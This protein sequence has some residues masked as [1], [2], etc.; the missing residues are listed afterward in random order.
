MPQAPAPHHQAATG[1]DRKKSIEARRCLHRGVPAAAATV[2]PARAP[3]LLAIIHRDM[4]T[5]Y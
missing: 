4:V 3:P 2:M 1:H 5:P